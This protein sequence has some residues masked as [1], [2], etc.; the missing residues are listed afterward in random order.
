[1]RYLHARSQL[2]RH[3]KRAKMRFQAPQW[4]R[5][6]VLVVVVVAI[7]WYVTDQVCTADPY[8]V[9]LLCPDPDA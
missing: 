8:S 9:W 3:K 7:L 5:L 2:L 6:V 4:L 1:M